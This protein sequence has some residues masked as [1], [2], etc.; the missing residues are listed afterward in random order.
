MFCVQRMA[1]EGRACVREHDDEGTQQRR[2]RF[3]RRRRSRQRGKKDVDGVQREA[4]R[5]LA[6]RGLRVTWRGGRERAAQGADALR[7]LQG[8]GWGAGDAP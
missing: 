7:A 2:Q 4:Q 3:R 5:A 8:D 6:L 1:R